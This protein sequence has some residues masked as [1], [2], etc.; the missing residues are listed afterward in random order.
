MAHEAWFRMAEQTRTQRKNRSH[1]LA[2][3]STMVR[4]ILYNPAMAH[5]AANVVELRFFGG[6]ENA[7]IAAALGLALAAVKQDR[8]QAR[9]WLHRGLGTG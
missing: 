8:T 3:A 9:A 7:G 5:R 6:L 4:R 2:G 1:F